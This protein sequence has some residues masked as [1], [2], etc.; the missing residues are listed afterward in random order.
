MIKGSLNKEGTKMIPTMVPDWS[1]V[2]IA[3]LASMAEADLKRRLSRPEASC[4]RTHI[5]HFGVRQWTDQI[6][7]LHSR[8]VHNRTRRIVARHITGTHQAWALNQRGG[9]FIH[10]V[11]GRSFRTWRMVVNRTHNWHCLPQ[12]L[13][14]RAPFP[15]CPPPLASSCLSAS[16]H[17][18][19]M[20]IARGGRVKASPTLALLRWQSRSPIPKGELKHV[21]PPTPSS[22]KTRDRYSEKGGLLSCWS[23]YLCGIL[24]ITA[25]I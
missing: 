25:P 17:L 6:G 4:S 12:I 9:M 1:R 11:M 13:P 5:H 15:L 23:K 19:I 3:L 21:S 2:N 16:C 8:G 18:R 24:G 14:P 22:N 7:G 20:W 10:R